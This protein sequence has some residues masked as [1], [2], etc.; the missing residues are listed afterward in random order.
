MVSTVVF[1]PLLYAIIITNPDTCLT[2][3][4]VIL[5]HGYLHQL[6]IKCSM[7]GFDQK[8]LIPGFGKCLHFSHFIQTLI[9]LLHDFERNFIVKLYAVLTGRKHQ[10]IF[11]R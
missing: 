3:P 6:I 5:K 9:L 10:Q 4:V 1:P 2:Q 7:M 11:W 8:V